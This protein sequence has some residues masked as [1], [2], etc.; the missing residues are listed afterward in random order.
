MQDPKD[1]LARPND[2]SDEEM[3]KTLILVFSPFVLL[4]AAAVFFF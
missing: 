4:I 1:V 2:R 3:T